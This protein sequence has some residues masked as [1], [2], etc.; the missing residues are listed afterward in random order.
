MTKYGEIINEK[1]VSVRELQREYR[2]VVNYINKTK[3]PVYVCRFNK[4]EVVIVGIQALEKIV[5]LNK[6]KTKQSKH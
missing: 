5:K 3:K 4:P 6:W 2:K 1:I